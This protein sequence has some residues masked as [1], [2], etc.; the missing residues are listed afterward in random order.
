MGAGKI[1]YE[2]GKPESQAHKPDEL[3]T[4]PDLVRFANA[5]FLGFCHRDIDVGVRLAHVS[6]RPGFSVIGEKRQSIRTLMAC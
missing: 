3:W 1:E 5:L 6:L 4:R 2:K